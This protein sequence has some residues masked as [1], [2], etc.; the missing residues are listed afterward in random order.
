MMIVPMAFNHLNSNALQ[1]CHSLLAIHIAQPI[2]VEP[3]EP[4]TKLVSR[5]VYLM[6]L[7]HGKR[8]DPFP[9]ITV[10]CL[11]NGMAGLIV[12]VENR[13]PDLVLTLELDCSESMNMVSSRNDLQTKD[14]VLP[15]SWQVI[16]ILTQLERTSG[17]NM[18]LKQRVAGSPYQG[19]VDGAALHQPP[20]TQSNRLLHQSY[21]I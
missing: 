12:G 2:L 15:R 7:K 10:F 5:A 13:N 14:A 17:Y 20:L 1:R 9:G 6:L 18:R 11:T 21:S 3:M 4:D 16:L 19:Y 8:S